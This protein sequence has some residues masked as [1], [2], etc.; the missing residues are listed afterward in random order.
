MKVAVT[1]FIVV[2]VTTAAAQEVPV[3]S[4]QQLEN[5]SEENI[6]DDA[7]LLNLDYLQ[8]HPINLNTASAEELQALRFLN[9]LQIDQLLRHR[10][11]LGPLLSI[12]ELQS[13]ASFDL[14]TIRK[15]LPYVFVG[16]G[17]TLPGRFMSRLR[18]GEHSLLFR[19]S[20]VLETPIGYDTSR[21]THYL[22]SRDR[23]FFRYRYQFKNQLYYGVLGDKDA[24][25]PFFRGA[26]R[27]G[28]DFYSA[29]LYA[30]DLGL[31]KTLAIGDYVVNLGQGLTQWQS[32]AFGKSAEALNIKRQSPT[33]LPYRSAGEFLFNRGLAITIGTK[34]WEFT[35]FI[36]SK[37]FSG[38]LSGDS[39]SR[40]TSF[41]SSGYH[42]TVNEIADRKG[43]NDF[44]WGNSLNFRSGS[45]KAAVN[46]VTHRFSKPFQK[47][48]APYNHFAVAGT[49]TLNSSFDFGYTFKNLHVFGEFA[50]DK[51]FNKAALGGLMLSLDPRVDLSLLYRNLSSGYQAL[52]GN[53]F[54]E[55]SLPGN[56][57]GLYTGLVI[58]PATG[59]LITAYAD[60]HQFPFL[61]YRVSAPARGMDRLL[62]VEYTPY[63]NT[64]LYVRFRSEIKSL[65]Q[66]VAGTNMA[67]PLDIDRKNLRLHFLTAASSAIDLRMRAE[68]TWLN[69]GD[70][71]EQGFL[72]YME[73]GYRWSDRLKNN[74]RLQYFETDSYDSR[75]YAYESD[76]LYSFST[77]AFFDKG[78]RVYLNSKYELSKKLTFWFRLARTIV[79]NKE[80]IGSG[81]D[82]VPS[83][84][85]TDIKLQ[86]RAI[87]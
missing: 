43:I 64:E 84:H 9:S 16:S 32:L 83:H 20:R 3:T 63:R 22:G 8:K 2:L 44:S 26:Q 27:T 45:F 76:I 67:Q 68:I 55:N 52:F 70:E 1:I 74:I 58:R 6:E 37:S 24:G 46:L 78:Y 77:P 17:S 65:D 71:Q 38:N 28:F 47:R 40:F 15:I 75:I 41:A 87:F 14:P 57:K 4:Q 66:M 50:L 11:L 49:E 85:K 12:Q 21:S 23:H 7:W 62:Q 31:I 73:I 53:A 5:I 48:D 81:L 59:W 19:T 13:I 18:G 29:H 10:K 72:S 56:E 33:I 86:I 39:L 42:R 36:S 30:R 54:T 51:N 25:E 61:K 79:T 60:V 80:T 69:G 82:M 35:G 34:K